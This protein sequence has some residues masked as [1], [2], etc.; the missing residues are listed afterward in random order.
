[1]ING[2]LVPLWKYT[3]SCC[4]PC[5]QDATYFPYLILEQPVS[6]MVHTCE[7]AQA[8]E[9]PKGMTFIA[10]AFYIV[11]EASGDMATAGLVIMGYFRTLT[12]GPKALSA[13]GI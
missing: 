10:G 6:G 2:L 11:R 1:M 5:D 3:S 8:R 7:T 12:G 9:E 13:E 4:W